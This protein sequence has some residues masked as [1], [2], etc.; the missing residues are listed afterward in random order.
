[1]VINYIENYCNSLY[2]QMGAPTSPICLKHIAACTT[3][4]V[5]MLTFAKKYME[6]LFLQ[7]LLD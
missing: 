4:T 7:F 6:E 1:M 3:S 2:G 5:E